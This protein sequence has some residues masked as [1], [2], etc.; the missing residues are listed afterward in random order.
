MIIRI[1]IIFY[2]LI[3]ILLAAN[4]GTSGYEFLRT[5]YSP[6][7]SAMA[8]GFLVLR[9]DINGIFQNPAVMAYTQERQ[10]C[11]NYNNYLLDVSGGQVGYTQRLT[12]HGQ[13]SASILYLNY[14]SFQES[15]EFAN[16]TGRS[17]SAGDVV[18]AISYA[19][20]LEERFFYGASFKFIHSQI[21]SYSSSAIAMDFGL[22]Y[23][24]PFSQD[25]Y[26]GFAMLNVGKSLSAYVHSK[27]S[28]PLSLRLGV[29]KKLAHLPLVYNFTFNDL[30]STEKLLVDHLK[31][32]SIGGEFTLSQVLRLRLGYDNQLH[33][34]LDTPSAK[35]TGVSLGFGVKWHTYRFDY[36][37]SS[38]GDLGGVHRF[39]VQGTF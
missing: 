6:R 5:D 23:E 11:F 18:A 30:N 9:G 1:Y 3:S 20:F 26:F 2:L 14:G 16:P 35:F 34:D 38:Y 25:L 39:G 7:S 36:S 13:L 10:F 4:H 21:D 8:G 24:A 27:E 29:S 28:L 22:I 15:D 37:F 12:D 17:F 31:K 19:D 32:F 33:S